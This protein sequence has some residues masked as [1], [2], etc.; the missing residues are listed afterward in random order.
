MEKV[1]VELCAPALATLLVLVVT[2][3]FQIK[4]NEW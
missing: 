4:R 1:I 2:V 3:I